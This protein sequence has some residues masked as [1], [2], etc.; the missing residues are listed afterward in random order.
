[1][2]P[3][4]ELFS[5]LLSHS[6]WRELKRGVTKAAFT[7]IKKHNLIPYW[8]WIKTTDWSSWVY[9]CFLLMWA[10]FSKRV[11]QCLHI[12]SYCI[13]CKWETLYDR[14]SACSQMNF[15]DRSPSLSWRSWSILSLWAAVK[16]LVQ[17]PILP[18]INTQI[19]KLDLTS[20]YVFVQSCY[21]Y[22]MLPLRMK[23]PFIFSCGRNL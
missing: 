2:F 5:S 9:W 10:N 6:R 11:R 22:V 23:S 12:S 14:C 18:A 21:S 7:D 8:C 19:K 13:R 17:S 4:T 20:V 15:R 16:V 3:L 1:M